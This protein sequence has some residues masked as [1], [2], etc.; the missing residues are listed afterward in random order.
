MFEML[1]NRRYARKRNLTTHIMAQHLEIKAN[2]MPDFPVLTFEDPARPDIVQTYSDLYQNAHRFAQAML[3]AG[4]EKGD[5]YAAIMYNYPEMVHL[6]AAS[7]ILGTVAVL[8]DP[9][10]KVH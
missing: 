2:S 9:R 4:L 3:D 8:I 1:K 10:S 7:G 5:R 6:M